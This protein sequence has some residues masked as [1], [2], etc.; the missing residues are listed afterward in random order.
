MNTEQMQK[1]RWKLEEDIAE[2]LE[3]FEEETGLQVDSVNLRRGLITRS[4]GSGETN[5]LS[6]TWTAVDVK[7]SLPAGEPSPIEAQMRRE[8]RRKVAAGHNEPESESQA[9]YYQRT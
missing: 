1:A 3:A 9:N 7:A 6:R 8:W 4:S 2:L 5:F